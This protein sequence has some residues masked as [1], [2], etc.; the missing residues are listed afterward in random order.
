MDLLTHFVAGAALGQAALGQQLHRKAAVMGGVAGLA[1]DADL[2]LTPF[3]DP[4][5]ALS[6]HRGITH[7]LP[8]LLGG[9]LLLWLWGRGG[10][11]PTARFGYG[12]F[13]LGLGSHI[14]LDLMT[15]Y[16]V[17]L[18]QPFTDRQFAVGSIAAVDL[19]FTLPLLGALLAELGRKP[20]G[21]RRFGGPIPKALLFGGLYL[22]FTAIN[23]AHVRS[24]FERA[25]ARQGHSYEG[26]ALVPASSA[27]LFWHGVAQDPQGGWC[28]GDY[29][30][31]DGKAQ[32]DFRHFDSRPELLEQLGNPKTIARLKWYAR[33]FFLVR[34][35]EDSIRM[36]H[37]KCH[38]TKGYQFP[39]LQPS[40][41]FFELKPAPD[42][43][44]TV[45]SRM[46]MLEGSPQSK[47]RRILAG[48][49]PDQAEIHPPCNYSTGE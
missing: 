10:E 22:A 43:I 41:G 20:L 44:L 38:L 7:S 8:L 4:V 31:L 9:T 37:L 34:K 42:G 15:N 47:W 28:V 23:K 11:K 46:K 16:G 12:L 21:P 36:Y 1:P 5:Q 26:L 24:L 25:L 18:F 27:N 14:L 45:Q 40:A 29:S 32:I 13:F 48:P 6:I 39:Y 49:F 3:L 19:V 30:L 2:L 17:Q 33:G 35:E